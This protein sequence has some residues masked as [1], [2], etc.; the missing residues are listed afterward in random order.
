MVKWAVDTNRQ[1]GGVTT[2]ADSLF[3]NDSVTAARLDKVERVLGIRG[4][5]RTAA[6]PKETG[7]VRKLWSLVF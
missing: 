3:Y 5:K 2:T 4:R 1:L 6:H 7:L